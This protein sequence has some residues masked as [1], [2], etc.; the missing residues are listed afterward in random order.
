MLILGACDCQTE[1]MAGAPCTTVDECA[2][3]EICSDGFCHDT[4]SGDCLDADGDGFGVGCARGPDC[5][6]GDANQTG[7]E[8]CGDGVDND[9]DG[10]I[11]ETVSG[12]GD[13]NP[14]CSATHIG[15]GGDEM[16]D[17]ARDDSDGVSVADD[18]AIVLDSRELETHFIWIANT[19][20]GTVSKV[21]TRTYVEVARYA[22]GP[23]GMSNDPSRTSV[24]SLG[25][26]YVGN[27]AHSSVTKISSL[28]AECPDTNG[29]GTITTSTGPDD[30]LAW[31]MDDCVLWHT[32]LAPGNLVRAVAAQDVEGLDFTV[33]TYVWVGAYQDR[34]IYKLDGTTGEILVDV[35][36][37]VQNYGFALDHRGNLWSSGRG[38]NALARI[39]TIACTSAACTI[40]E[41]PLGRD[42]YGITVDFNGR[43]WTANHGND[44][45]TRY[46][47]DTG[48]FI[49][50]PVGRDC[51]GI[52]ADAHGWVWA[53]CMTDGVLRL[54]MADPAN[55]ALVAGTAQSSKGMAVDFDGKIWSIN[56]SSG[57][58][59]TVITPGAT[60]SEYTVETGIAD[61]VVSP[62]TYSDMTGQQLRLATNP[63]GF[64][65]RVFEGC[66]GSDVDPSWLMLDYEA[67]TPPG[68]EIVFRVR[69][70]DERTALEAAAWVVVAQTPPD[71]SPADVAAAL[72]A[73]SVE[74]MRFLEVEAIL[75]ST[76]TSGMVATPRLYA[77][78]P[79]HE[80]PPPID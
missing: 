18:G 58:Y 57:H 78:G 76:R 55:H 43:V 5:D 46:D 30:V 16:F 53:A 19:P 73:A 56:R 1:L 20:E 38:D 4:S 74:P 33:S 71:V 3:G 40:D 23:A 37:P 2:A 66:P 32:P 48:E 68:T 44:T 67:V 60:L 13:C 62:Y 69:T 41:I 61:Q 6:D 31:G 45:I 12:C 24:N 51:H 28:G 15:R 27:R 7:T 35:V 77:F 47:P 50:T 72:T 39:D 10:E 29:D 14:Y 22:T 21:D 63:R 52:A 8:M 80:C 26:V 9:C 64:Y 79:S 49:H 25:D 34:R 59:A 42:P 70:A 17:T 65:R 54:D 11:D 75:T 36:G